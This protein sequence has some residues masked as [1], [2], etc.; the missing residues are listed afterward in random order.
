MEAHGEE[1]GEDL[2]ELLRELLLESGALW[3]PRRRDCGVGGLWLPGEL[4]C[5]GTWC[6]MC[7]RRVGAEESLRMDAEAARSSAL[8]I[9]AM[10]ALGNA[11]VSLEGAFIHA[12]R[13]FVAFSLMPLGPPSRRH[14]TGVRI[15]LAGIPTAAGG[16]AAAAR[17]LA[18]LSLLGLGMLLSPFQR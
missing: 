4:F 1:P 3:L 2:V 6:G 16:C 13:A 7:L 9:G 18:A 5:G 15:T 10:F 8:M 12:S 17:E 14:V 11:E